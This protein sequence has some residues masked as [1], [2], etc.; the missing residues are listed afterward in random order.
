MNAFGGETETLFGFGLISPLGL[1]LAALSASLKLDQP[2]KF[3][4]RACTLPSIC[5]F[6]LDPWISRSPS[7][8]T[9]PLGSGKGNDPPIGLGDI[10]GDADTDTGNGNGPTSPASTGDRL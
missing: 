2:E 8:L 7:G 4:R 1:G 10:C 3:L 9:A 6:Q 5:R